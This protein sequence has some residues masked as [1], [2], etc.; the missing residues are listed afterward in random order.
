MEVNLRKC[1][2]VV[3]TSRN[4]GR[5]AAEVQSDALRKDAAENREKLLAA[6][7][8]LFATHG[9]EAPLETVAAEAGVGIATLY[10]RFPTR[11]ELLAAVVEQELEEYVRETERAL[12]VDEAWVGFTSFLTAMCDLQASQPGLCHAPYLELSN[13]ARVAALRERLAALT[14]QHIERA[15][16]EGSL[17]P[18]V[19]PYD[20]LLLASANAGVIGAAAEPAALTRYRELMFDALRAR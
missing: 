4:M 13:A 20:V 17:R 9:T 7:R 2:G 16:A 18:D 5:P 14:A 10:R 11:E 1:Y 19:T 3:M 12:E 8:R 15:Q 6:A